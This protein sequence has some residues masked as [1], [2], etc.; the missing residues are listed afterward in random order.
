MALSHPACKTLHAA[1][2]IGGPKN[3]N[4]V[5]S[6]C[7]GRKPYQISGPVSPHPSRTKFCTRRFG[8]AEGPPP[9][10]NCTVDHVFGSN[11]LSPI[12]RHQRAY[13]P[14]QDIPTV[15]R[16]AGCSLGNKPSL[17][18][19]PMAN[20]LLGPR[21]VQVALWHSPI[22]SAVPRGFLQKT[23]RGDIRNSAR[24]RGATRRVHAWAGWHG[25]PIA[26]TKTCHVVCEHIQ[27]TNLWNA[28]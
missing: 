22:L 20:L 17:Q 21:G 13:S 2:S 14:P 4:R 6:S 12:F 10:H 16:I 7:S 5:L 18:Y 26:V 11:W 8:A 28:A 27:A 23:G 1:S 25:N 24:A 19:K 9:Q 3:A 15:I